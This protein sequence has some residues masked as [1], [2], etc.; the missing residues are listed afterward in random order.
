MA[1][2]PQAPV[3][4]PGGAPPASPVIFQVALFGRRYNV[5][6]QTITYGLFVL[7]ALAAIVPLY[8]LARHKTAATRDWVFIWGCV[9]AVI[10]AVGGLVNLGG[11]KF[12]THLS[13]VDR[14]RLL[15]LVVGGA[16]GLAT[17]ALGVILPFTE[18]YSGHLAAGLESWRKHPLSLVGPLGA[19]LGGL[20]L[21]FVSLQLGRGMERTSQNVRRLIYG[22]NA[23]LTCLLLLAVLA[24]PNVLA[25]AEPFKS[26]FFTRTYDATK[27]QVYTLDQSTQ[28]FLRGM[29]EPVKVYVLMRLDLPW[30]QDVKTLLENCRTYTNKIQY[31]MVPVDRRDS[32]GRLLELMQKYKLENARGILVVVGE[33]PKAA[34]EFI[35][36]ND[37]RETS[38]AM[39]REGSYTFTGESALISAI[40]ALT[41]GKVVVYFTQGNGEPELNAA[42]PFGAAPRQVGL[43]ELRTRLTQRKNFEVKE[44]RLTPKT[45][46][47]P[48]DASAVV[49]VRP[50]NMP[51]HAVGVLRSYMRGKKGKLMVLADPVV[52][53][54]AGKKVMAETGL[55]GLLRDFNVKLGMNR[56]IWV[57]S[58]NP[59]RVQA[60]TNPNATN[61]VARA[62]FPHPMLATVF[63]FEDVRPVESQGGAAGMYTVDSLVLVAI[64]LNN[65]AVL[66]V[67]VDRNPR[68][69]IAGLREMVKD[70]PE[71]VDAQLSHRDLPMAVAVSETAG[72][73]VPRDAAHA[74]MFQE[75]PRLVV[76]G[77][78]TWVTDD[79]DYGLRGRLGQTNF[80][81]F[82]SCLSWLRERPDIGKEKGANK[83]RQVYDLNIADQNIS[84]L[85]WLPLWL[86]LL[87]VIGL[88]GGV[89][90]VRRR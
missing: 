7:A 53:E 40:K 38:R 2:N 1:S 80:D 54:E 5:T 87:G 34:Q 79:R 73:G 35:K 74:G 49:V 67:D 75:T 30:T 8:L 14:Q 23:L 78:A 26:W 65:R 81:L 57:T 51:P 6:A 76:F 9:V 84:R 60:V 15:L 46:R 69:V 28:N 68:A 42:M 55:E 52:R 37:L 27:L 10:F 29:Q 70:D 31:E 25:Y 82:S 63:T 22:Y 90:V 24:L 58:E 48:A 50:V 56:I 83:T 41:E 39:A 85:V 43:S 62:F 18:P 61:P 59:L 11:Y 3:A 12:A 4:A 47:V 89:W 71:K 33:E 16:A 20:A 19:L 72:R 21:M 64:Q 66:T 45:K 13:E 32:Q 44:L 88:G 86:I 17:A 77:N 36:E